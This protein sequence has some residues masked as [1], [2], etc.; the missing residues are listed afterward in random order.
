MIAA[1][2]RE[3]SPSSGFSLV[4]VMISLAI[5]SLI[6]GIVLP[7]GLRMIERFEKRRQL[8]SVE[9]LIESQRAEAISQNKLIRHDAE[10]L[11]NIVKT[12]DSS[13][14]VQI[15]LSNPLVFSPAGV[16]QQAQVELFSGEEIGRV[17]LLNPNRCDLEIIE[18]RNQAL[19]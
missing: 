7:N 19:R 14:D 5:I 13:I 15:V 9:I 2:R 16:C 18:L 17:M 11:T 8:D 4:E 3:P 1:E 10:S 12:F 6:V